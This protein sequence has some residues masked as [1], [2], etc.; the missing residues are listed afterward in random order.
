MVFEGGKITGGFIDLNACKLHGV[1]GDIKEYIDSDVIGWALGQIEYREGQIKYWDGE[2]WI[3]AGA[4]EFY[5]REEVDEL[6]KGYVTKEEF[7]KVKDK[8]IQWR[9]LV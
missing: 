1:A 9:E 6:L 3:V 8:T 4:G 2:N 7:N 5:T